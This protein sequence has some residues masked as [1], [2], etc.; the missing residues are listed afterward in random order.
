MRQRTLLVSLFLLLGFVATPRGVLAGNFTFEC[1]S[2]RYVTVPLGTESH[3]FQAPLSAVPPGDDWVDVTFEPHL[4]DYWSAS[5][6][7]SG[8]CY[9]SDQ[10]IRLV[11]GAVGRLDI[12]IFP[13]LSTPGMGWV[14]ITIRSVADP[15]DV[16]RCTYTLYCGMAIPSVS[17]S[18][19]DTH[20]TQWL[21]SGDFAEFFSPIREYLPVLDTL[22]IHMIP[23]LPGD[24][25]AQFCQR[26]GGSCFFDRGKFPLWPGRTDSLW[27]EVFLGAAPST[28]DLDFVIQSKRNPS[29]AQYAHYQV[30]LGNWSAEASPA[31]VEAAARTWTLPNPSAGPASIMLHNRVAGPGELTIFGADG[32]VVRSFP[33]LSLAAGVV[34]VRWDGGDDRGQAVPPGIYFYR[35]L[36]GGASHRGTIVR[37]R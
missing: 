16:A 24:W 36:A 31:T 30:F 22:L 27:V 3:E 37:T 26:P 32:R 33:R 17:Y 2:D 20:A 23:S 15:T 7:H 5:W 9:F 12:D 1:K 19:D 8:T 18:V 10:R 11:S 34:S 25:G 35:F 28:G 4:P 13:V 6:C 21:A 14:D 29:I